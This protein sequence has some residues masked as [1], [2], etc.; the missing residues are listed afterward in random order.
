[1]ARGTISN[2][3]AIKS[4]MW[5]TSKSVKYIEDL[6]GPIDINHF[7]RRQENKICYVENIF[8]KGDKN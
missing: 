4:K 1:M 6:T 8:L 5:N 7:L 2:I 3:S